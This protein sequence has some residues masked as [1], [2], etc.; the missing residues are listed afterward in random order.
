MFD[1][2]A[3]RENFEHFFIVFTL[4]NTISWL[5]SGCFVFDSNRVLTEIFDPKINWRFDRKFWLKS[6]FDRDF[7][8]GPPTPRGGGT[9]SHVKWFDRDLALP[10]IN[11]D[12]GIPMVTR[13]VSRTKR[14]HQHF[15]CFDRV[16]HCGSSLPAVSY[17]TGCEGWGQ[18]LLSFTKVPGSGCVAHI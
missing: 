15:P 18:H 8:E 5:S 17:Q 11:L 2:R 4:E 16:K 3:A 10:P 6:R 1:S 9:F 7:S 14:P 13:F 12:G